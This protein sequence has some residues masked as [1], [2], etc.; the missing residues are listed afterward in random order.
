[1]KEQKI[2][3]ELVSDRYY[4]AC[5]NKKFQVFYTLRF[6]SVV[7]SDTRAIRYKFINEHGGDL[8]LD[9]EELLKY[10][11][12]ELELIEKSLGS[13]QQFSVEQWKKLV[14]GENEDDQ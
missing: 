8:L 5:I 3:L 14:R 10:E 6:V 4:Q 12:K 2:R 1:M 7:I 13:S 9:T 11:V